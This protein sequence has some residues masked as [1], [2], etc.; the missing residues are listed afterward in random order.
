VQNGSYFS[1]DTSCIFLIRFYGAALIRA[2]HRRM[3][4]LMNPK[5]SIDSF[6]FSFLGWGGTEFTWYVGH[7]LAYC[8]SPGCER[9]AVD[10]M[11]IGRG[12]RLKQ[13]VE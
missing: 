6:F 9:K 5:G 1:Q 4:E 2:I 3:T 12:N 7:C 11:R 10:G 8:T 13:S